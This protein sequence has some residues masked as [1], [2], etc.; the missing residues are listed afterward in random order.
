MISTSSNNDINATHQSNESQTKPKRFKHTSI[1][2]QTD[3]TPKKFKKVGIVSKRFSL[4]EKATL[5]ILKEGQYG[6][7]Y[8][9]DLPQNPFHQQ[10]K[11]F[12]SP[13]TKPPNTQY[14]KQ[15]LRD[16]A[17]RS[18]S[19]ATINS[20]TTYNLTPD[21]RRQGKKPADVNEFID[22][23][24]QQIKIAQ[25]QFLEKKFPDQFE[26]PSGYK[27][28]KG[29]KLLESGV[30]KQTK[31][32]NKKKK[33]CLLSEVIGF[34]DDEVELEQMCETK[35]I[36][37][38]NETMPNQP[39][40]TNTLQRLFQSNNTGADEK[41][42]DDFLFDSSNNN[43]SHIGGKSPYFQDKNTLGCSAKTK[44][45]RHNLSENLKKFKN[46]STNIF[47]EKSEQTP[48]N[49]LNNKS[50]ELTYPPQMSPCK[51]RLKKTAITQNISQTNSLS[52]K[53]PEIPVIQI[54]SY[55]HTPMIK[56]KLKLGTITPLFTICVDIIKNQASSSNLNLS[57]EK[58]RRGDLTQLRQKIYTKP[59]PSTT[60]ND[61]E[62][63]STNRSFDILKSKIFGTQKN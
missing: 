18:I 22:M 36:D 10:S 19:L 41:Q 27:F 14:S 34:K 57:P 61:T 29:L 47:M 39:P 46:L 59:V 63:L 48:T 58:K 30:Y 52:P 49:I 11:D 21:D 51:I 32:T 15:E 4:L 9:P 62:N 24:K 42:S 43:S 2:G 8:Q 26:N 31:R 17:E 50:T 3:Q 55:S 40:A 28:D 45:S 38:E 23:K 37:I 53:K 16:M 25:N 5:K 60:K 20:L 1:A 35:S 7:S 44:S 12:Q 56:G 13:D 54:S 33:E 6:V